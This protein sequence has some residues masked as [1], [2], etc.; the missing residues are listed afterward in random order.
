MILTAPLTLIIFHWERKGKKVKKISSR[1]SSPL[2]GEDR[3]GGEKVNSTPH[4]DPLP[5][6]GEGRKGKDLTAPLTFILSRKGREGDER[7]NFKRPPHPDP[8]PRSGEGREGKDLTTPLTLIISRKGREKILF[9]QK[10][11]VCFHKFWGF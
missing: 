6:S 3:G 1:T 11:F 8:L 9:N 2:T 4:P 5:R 7:K 10:H